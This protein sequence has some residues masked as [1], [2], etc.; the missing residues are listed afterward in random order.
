MSEKVFD[1]FY[2]LF[3]GLVILLVVAVLFAVGYGAYMETTKTVADTYTIECEV[4]QMAYA[5]EQI[6][7]SS[8][9]PVYKMGVRNENFACT[10]DINATQFAQYAIG[11][12]VQVKITIYR[13]ADGSTHTDYKLIG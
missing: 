2:Y 8:S 9:K 13:W 1:V 7:R 10:F 11:D 4:T 6:S 12:T 5:E 3:M